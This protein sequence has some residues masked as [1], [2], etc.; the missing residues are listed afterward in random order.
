M[1]TATVVD[2]IGQALWK[3]WREGVLDLKEVVHGTDRGS[4][5]TSIRFAERLADAGIRPS[6]GAVGSS[7][8]NALAE[9]INGLYKT[10]LIKPRKLWRTIEEAEP[11]TAECA[12]WFNNHRLYEY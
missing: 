2:S 3:R 7:N 8:D 11:A 10:D 4:Q 6:A 1:T 12:D 9:T 5:R